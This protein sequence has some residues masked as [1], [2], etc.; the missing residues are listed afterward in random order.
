LKSFLSSLKYFLFITLITTLL[1]SHAIYSQNKPNSEKAIDT[2]PYIRFGNISTKFTK[3]SFEL[4]KGNIVSNVLKVVNHDNRVVNFTVDALFPGGWTRIDDKDKLYSAKPKDTIIVP[5]IISPTKLVNGNTEIVINVFIIAKDGQQLGNNFF[6]LTTKKKVAW[7]IDLKNNTNYYFK[8]DENVKNFRFSIDNDGNYKQDVF[9]SYTI[10]RKDLILTD[11]LS[12]PIKDTSKTFTLDPGDSKEFNYTAQATSFNERNKKRISLNNYSPISNNERITRT[13]VINSSEPKISKTALQK[14]TKLNFIKLPNEIEAKPYG[15]PYLPMIVD[16]TAQNIMDER[17]FL[18]LNLQG[19]KQLNPRASLLYFT[20]FNYSNSFFTNNVFKNAPWYVGYFDDKKSIEIGQ[21]NGDL[22][23]ASAAGKGIKVGYRFNEQHSAGAFYTNSAGFFNTTNSIVTYGG[24]YKLKYNE[25]IRLNA[26]AGRSNNKFLNRTS[27]VASIQPSVRF[28]N[29][30]T[31]SLLGGFNNVQFEQNNIPISTNGYIIGT[32]YSSSLLKRKLKSN[33]SV[34]YNDRFFSNGTTE[35][36]FINQRFTYDLSKEWLTIFTGNY[37]KVRVFNRNTDLFL[38]NQETLFANMIFSKR[39]P[40]GSYQPG[41]FYESRN[42]PNNSFVLRGV[43][44]RYSLFNLEQNFLSSI[45]TRAG[46]AKPKDGIDKKEYFSLEV[47]GL[48]RYETWNLTARYNLG[49]FSS[50]TSQ[51]NQ[52]NAITPQSLRLSIQNQHLFT[53]RHFALESSLIYSFNNVFKNHSVGLFPQAFYFSNSGWRFGL[54]ANYIFTTSDFSSVFDASDINANP[55]QQAIGPTTNS[56][57]NLN[58]SLRKE[59][60]IPIPF[61]KQ[62]AATTTF[63][64]FLDING[65]GIKEKDETS[66]QNVVI[67][68]NKSEVITNF[69]GKATIKNLQLDKYKLE[70]ISLEDLRGWFANVKDSIVINEDGINYIPFVRGIKVYGDVIVDRQKIA[71]TNEKPLDLS[72]IKISALKDDKV[73][74]T[75]TD[76][77]GRFEF[78]LPFGTYTITMDEGI[79]NERFRVT[80]NNLPVRLRNNQDGVYVSFYIVEKRRKVIFKDFS[81]KK[82]D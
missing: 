23:G 37:Q 3:P 61:A 68:V 51:Q 41:V 25:N 78:Y 20:Q 27:T 5:I 39:T 54:S 34:R 71:V 62:S 65:N 40:K 6:T 36:A 76:N 15:Y 7:S 48:F 38:Y 21:V 43:N 82:N 18:S 75:L 32:N 81:K 35:R 24:W 13:L 1:S 55:N 79:L 46:Y 50:I 60:G 64:S 77:N 80:R 31:V 33:V 11:T 53:N 63:I 49:T 59:F 9:V 52:N 67:K 14:K 42:F 8:N 58:F 45:F 72:R 22:I 47:N 57:L 19:F 4:K 10:P 73:Y 56:N 17:S 12:N 70:T 28:L 16:L 2:I 30:H 26:S 44:F 74:N 29:S 69:E 66:I